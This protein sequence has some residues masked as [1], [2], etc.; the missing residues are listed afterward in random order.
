[1]TLYQNKYRVESTRISGR[2]YSLPGFYFITTNIADTRVSLGEIIDGKMKPNTFGKIVHDCWKNLPNHYPN[3]TCDSFVIM[4]NH[5]HCII[6]LH[7]RGNIVE[8]G[9]HVGTGH[10]V[11]TGLRPV[12]NNEGINKPA[13]VSEIMRALKSFSARQINILRESTGSPV[14]QARFYDRIIRNKKELWAT[15]KYIVNNPAN[16][17]T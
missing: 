9:H 15:R 14:L 8:T 6:Q 1:M 16:W 17:K 4:P 5:I 2:N 11:E 13:S 3:M 7:D 12:S 10:H